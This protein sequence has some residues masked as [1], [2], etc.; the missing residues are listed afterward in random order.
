M[1]RGVAGHSQMRRPKLLAGGGPVKVYP[2]LVMYQRTPFSSGSPV[3]GV[4][5][6]L[7]G[8]PRKKVSGTNVKVKNPGSPSTG[9][10]FNSGTV[11]ASNGVE[12]TPS[13]P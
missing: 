2:G 13:S 4:W 12:A 1:G 9:V 6:M 10:I 8:V 7:L 5:S 3:Y 11:P